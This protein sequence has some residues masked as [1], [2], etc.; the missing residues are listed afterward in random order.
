VTL[1][2]LQ[3]Q[4]SF[5]VRYMWIVDLAVVQSLHALTKYQYGH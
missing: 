4:I 5:D 3:R 1:V 2:P